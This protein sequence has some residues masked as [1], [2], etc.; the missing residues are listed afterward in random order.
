MKDRK[1][2]ARLLTR[3]VRKFAQRKSEKSSH[4]M[5]TIKQNNPIQNFN[6]VAQGSIKAVRNSSTSKQLEFCINVTN[7][8]KKNMI[9][10]IIC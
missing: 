2:Q 3:F 8:S 7:K 10:S 9:K 5:K 6:G 4:R 1:R